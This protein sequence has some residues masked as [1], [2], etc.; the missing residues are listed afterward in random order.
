MRWGADGRV[1]RKRLGPRLH[2]RTRYRVIRDLV[3]LDTRKSRIV[4]KA[5]RSRF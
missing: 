1:F 3:M 2:S 4:G 5:L